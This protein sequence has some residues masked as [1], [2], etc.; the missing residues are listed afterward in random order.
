MTQHWTM[1]ESPP[2]EPKEGPA[3]PSY[4]W[5]CGTVVLT[6]PKERADVEAGFKCWRCLGKETRELNRRSQTATEEPK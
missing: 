4:C 2:T 3:T 5:E 1:V 6:D